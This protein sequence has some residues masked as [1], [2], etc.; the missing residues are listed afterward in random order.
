MPVEVSIEFTNIDDL[1][2]FLYN[3]EKKMIES[4]EDR[5]LYKIQ[6]VSYDIISNDEPQITDI[7][8]IAYYYYDERFDDSKNAEKTNNEQKTA[9][10]TQTNQSIEKTV[11]NQQEK[12]NNSQAENSQAKTTTTEKENKVGS[13]FNS[14]F[15]N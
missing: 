11:S 4:T 14:F 7:A 3:I 15:S 1:V 6:S 9:S 8:M 13:F 12:T 2:D 10:N 5:I